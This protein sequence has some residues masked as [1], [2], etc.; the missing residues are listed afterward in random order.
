MITRH[1]VALT[2]LCSMIPAGIIFSF[3]PVTA[4]LVILGTT[5]GAIIPDIHMHRSKSSHI[6][7]IPWAIAEAGRRLCIPL[8]QTLYRT[9]FGI[10][11]HPL[12]KRMTHSL[13]GILFYFLMFTIISEGLVLLFPSQLSLLAAIGFVGG[14]LMGMILHLMEDMCTK[15][16][17]FPTF[18]F[19]ERC[20]A[21]SIRPCNTED[22]RITEFHIIF[23]II[24]GGFLSIMFMMGV[25]ATDIV[26]EGIAVMVLCVGS[27]IYMSDI[28][29]RADIPPQ[30]YNPDKSAI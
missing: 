22:P 17:I 23:I 16:G 9:I 27:M 3:N 6:R 10:D 29:V 21:G 13:P 11:T 30:A 12:D 14:M 1:H 15:K 25:S 7:R 4:V 2:L 18:P 20:V 19:S 26:P 28:H 5:I 8:M 24:T